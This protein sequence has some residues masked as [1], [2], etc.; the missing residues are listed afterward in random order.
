MFDLRPLRVYRRVLMLLKP[1]KG[2]AI[3][4]TLANLFL[5][6][7]PFIEP[8]LFGRTID[9]L[10]QAS[11][12]GADATLNDGIRIFGIWLLVGV[13][14]IA[15]GALVSLHADRL[16]HR[17][18]LEV[19]AQYFAHVLR[20][21]LAFHREAHSGRLLSIML[22]GGND[23]FNLWLSMFRSHL[24][25]F[26]ALLVL[27]PL[28]LFLNWKLAIVLI[29]LTVVFTV[30][31]A[32]VTHRT[33]NAQ[34]EVQSQH[35]K[36]AEQAGDAIGNVLLVQSFVRQAAELRQLRRVIDKVLKAQFPVLNW[37]A[38]VSI[39]SGAASTMTIICIFALG[40]WLN[41]K[42]EASVGSIVT[43]MGFAT[44]L[45]GRLGQVVG[46][47]NNLFMQAPSLSMFFDVLDARSMV[48][49]LPGAYPLERVVGRVEFNDIVFSYES[50]KKALDKISFTAEPGK[51]VALV[52]ETGAGKSTAMGL[53]LR[54]YDPQEGQVLVDGI[55]IRQVTLDSLRANIGVVFQESLL[56]FRTIEENLK[57]GRPDAT[58]E[59]MV[60]AARQAQAHDFIM[61]QPQGYQ[62]IIGE[63]GSKLS[64]GERQRLAIARVILKNPS[65]LILDEATSA[66]DSATETKVQKAFQALMQGRTTLIIAHRLATI[67]N[68][69]LILVFQ[70]GRIVERGTF[71]ELAEGGGLF[72]QLVSAQSGSLRK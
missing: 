46:F 52:G 58:D 56:F 45:I 38:A 23:L 24:S 9:L 42:G 6:A 51:V 4:L 16:A 27:L 18:R 60:A 54:Q 55:D 11:S 30:L 41:L 25:T 2:R 17:L 37:W 29:A 47:V 12:R 35:T 40:A 8:I 31:T 68:A 70:Q 50:G 32:F 43:F 53:L 39:L 26:V 3:I 59:E 10:T 33:H 22:S 67:R 57:V 65:I 36:L 14:G 20:L 28:T 13:G 1:V 5:A 15:I 19:M 21:H 44:H 63:R 49:D 64:G 7:V 72:A 61:Q 62:T 48:Q 71:D 66:L 34:Y 69:D